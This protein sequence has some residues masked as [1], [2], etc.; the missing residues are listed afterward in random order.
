MLAPC[1]SLEWF[2]FL[3]NFLGWQVSPKCH[4]RRQRGW[5]NNALQIHTVP[6]QRGTHYPSNTFRNHLSQIPGMFVQFQKSFYCSQTPLLL[7][8]SWWWWPHH[9]EHE[10]NREGAP[11]NISWLWDFCLLTHSFTPPSC[12]GL[13]VCASPHPHAGILKPQWWC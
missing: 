5:L 7:S 4:W 1:F 11:H 12:C 13:D 2:P 3:W 10:G 8:V 9:W 6:A